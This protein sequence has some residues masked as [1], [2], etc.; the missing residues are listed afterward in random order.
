MI[1]NTRRVFATALFLSIALCAHGQA[2]SSG[3][4]LDV[5]K[6][7]YTAF[8]KKDGKAMQTLTTSDF[9]YV[10]TE[11][12]LSG[13]ELNEA[14]KGCVLKTF[15]LAGEKIKT[16]GANAAVLTY[17]SHQDEA[18]DGHAMPSTLVN[19]DVFVKRN[20]KWLVTNHMETAKAD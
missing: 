14:T 15:T 9:T 10:G 11:G 1:T 8:Q 18:C 6:R 16:I 17:I 5:S 19:L 3:Q 7:T 13:P 20:G 4:L 2:P 12:V